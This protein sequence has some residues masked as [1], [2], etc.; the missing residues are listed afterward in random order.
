MEGHVNRAPLFDD[1]NEQNYEHYKN[2]FPQVHV[3][4]SPFRVLFYIFWL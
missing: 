1:K 4:A 3:N 2:I